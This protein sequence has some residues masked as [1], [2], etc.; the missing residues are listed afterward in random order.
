MQDSQREDQRS[1]NRS[2]PLLYCILIALQTA[3]FLGAAA[4]LTL[5]YLSYR[6]ADFTQIFILTGLVLIGPWLLISLLP[7]FLGLQ[8]RELRRE[9]LARQLISMTVICAALIGL[10]FFVGFHQELW[11]HVQSMAL[12]CGNFV[13]ELWRILASSIGKAIEFLTTFMSDKALLWFSS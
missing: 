12:N 11:Q 2:S 5:F 6:S 10:S 13:R 8:D 9:I 1:W 7:V 3:L 4:A